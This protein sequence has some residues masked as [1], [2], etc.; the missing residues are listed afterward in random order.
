MVRIFF[1]P[2]TI[3]SDAEWLDIP[4][5][6]PLP[7]TQTEASS[8]TKRF[9]R[10]MR[11]LIIRV[12][13]AYANPRPGLLTLFQCERLSTE[14][15]CWLYLSG[16]HV[17]ASMGFYSYVSPRLRREAKD[18]VIDIQNS[19]H[20]TYTGLL[21]SRRVDAVQL[22]IQAQQ[23]REELLLAQQTNAAQEAYIAQLKAELFQAKS[24]STN[25]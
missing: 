23:Y 2:T 8:S 14:T 1:F 19:F 24:T 18:R 16:Q 22:S 6:G 10:L 7:R 17:N 5:Q 4:R 21:E 12:S 3:S 13:N 20:K 15:G 11:D 9:N 25:L